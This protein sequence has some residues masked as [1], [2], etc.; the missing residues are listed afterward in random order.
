MN[1]SG[2]FNYGMGGDQV[3]NQEN[4]GQNN[5]IDSSTQQQQSTQYNFGMMD[6]NNMDMDHDQVSVPLLLIFEIYQSN[7]YLSVY[8][9]S[10]PSKQMYVNL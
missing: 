1:S 9:S 7:I 3:D 6:N 4:D 5:D 8:L 2:G 10:Y